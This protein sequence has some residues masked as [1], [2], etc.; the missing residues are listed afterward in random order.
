MKLQVLISCG[1]GDGCH[2]GDAGVANEWIHKNGITDETC[3][4]YQVNQLTCK[5]DEQMFKQEEQTSITDEETCG[6][7]E[8]TSKLD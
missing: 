2:G 5:L 1:P 7:V 8:Q 3:S 4:I 6:L